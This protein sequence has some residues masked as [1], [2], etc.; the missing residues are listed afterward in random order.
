MRILGIDFGLAK[1]G[2][3]IAEENLVQ[4]LGVVRRSG[5]FLSKIVEICQKNRIEKIIVGLP[6]GKIEKK[7]KKF[8]R[9][10]SGVSNLPL[11]FQDETLTTHEAVAK[12]IEAGRTRQKRRELEDA[13]AAACI[14]QEYLEERRG[15]V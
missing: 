10:I 15:S 7:V 8:A 2:L 6:E 5:K 14:L 9:E 11:E 1:I 13:V 3:A 12:M 4:P